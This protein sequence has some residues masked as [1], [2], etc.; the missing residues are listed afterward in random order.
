MCTVG[1]QAADCWCCFSWKSHTGFQLVSPE[2]LSLT[3]LRSPDAYSTSC[4]SFTNST[5]DLQLRGDLDIAHN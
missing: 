1:W 2:S 5:E 4:S 3:P